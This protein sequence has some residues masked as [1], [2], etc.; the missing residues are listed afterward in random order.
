MGEFIDRSGL[1]GRV[2]VAYCTTCAVGRSL[3]PL[4]DVQFLY[5]D[6]SS[7]DF[8]PGTSGIARIMKRLAFR[9]DARGLL[10]QVDQDPRAVI[11]FACGSG[12]FTSVLAE[13]LGRDIQVTGTDFHRDPPKDIGQAE[14]R[15][16][17]DLD[18]LSGS[19]D[20]VLAMHVLEHDDDP[21]TLLSRIAK[22]VRPGGILVI[23]VPNVDCIWTLVF[24]RFWDSWYLPYHRIH[25]S[26][27]SLRR[28]VESSGF[29]VHS[30][31]DVSLPTMGR[32]LA[33]LFGK[34][35]G[36]FFIALAALLQPLQWG[37]E[38]ISRRPAALRIIAHRP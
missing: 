10:K 25:F 14:Y 34:R 20:L 23:E 28:I 38:R 8:Q 22:L 19:A 37:I 2:S 1:I 35:N 17:Q 11:D 7:Q 4:P 16:I 5:A 33:N 18:D 26:R 12:L 30:E 24:G 29:T 13:I 32:S 6:R 36:T 21:Q 3:P 9:R 31:H 15:S 27:N